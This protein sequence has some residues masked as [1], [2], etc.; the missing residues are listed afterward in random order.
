MINN[1]FPGMG[2]FAQAK[3]YDDSVTEP[4]N[5]AANGSLTTARLAWRMRA[6]CRH[7]FT[8]IE[9][10]IV[11]VI[12]GLLVGGILV[13]RDLIRAAELRAD[14]S[15]VDKFDAAVNTFRLK[16]N[17]VPGDC[18]NATQFLEGAYNGNGDGVIEPSLGGFSWLY[19]F[20]I[21]Y[22]L[23]Y[24]VDHLA[25][26]NLIA[27]APFEANDALVTV[28]PDKAMPTLPSG[29]AFVV[30]GE[31]QRTATDYVWSGKH[32]YRLGTRDAAIPGQWEGMIKTSPAHYTP[33]DAYFIDSK[34]DDG[35]AVYGRVT[36]GRNFPTPD[37]PIFLLPTEDYFMSDGVCDPAA[38]DG[39]VGEFGLTAGTCEYDLIL[40]DKLVGLWI[41]ASF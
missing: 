21:G 26:A 5:A 39:S 24:A 34:I 10:S 38:A 27:V 9:L 2:G 18:V 16:Y 40:K 8:L 23:A 36:A 35:K 22:E 30:V 13:G 1:H 12:I 6:S 33:H 32:T 15:A 37:L 31:Y 14:I 29:S 3:K 11:L 28:H 19:G 7:G 25:R 41:R 20:Y 4:R 17:C